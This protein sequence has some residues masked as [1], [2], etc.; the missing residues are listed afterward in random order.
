LDNAY[1]D[2]LI[3][4]KQ[5]VTSRLQHQ[6]IMELCLSF[7]CDVEWESMPSQVRGYL[8]QRVVGKPC[9]ISQDIE[10]W[11]FHRLEK[12]RKCD[13]ENF[14]ARRNYAACLITEQLDLF[15]R[16]LQHPTNSESPKRKSILDP[17]STIP[18]HTDKNSRQK[19]KELC[20]FICDKLRSCA[21]MLAVALVAD[22]EFQ[23]EL[24]YALQRTS[25]LTQYP[26]RILATRIWIFANTMQDLFLPHLLVCTKML[27]IQS[28]T[29]YF[30]FMADLIYRNY[31]KPFAEPKS[32]SDT[33]LFISKVS[34]K[35]LL[36]SFTKIWMEA[37][38]CRN[39]PAVTHQNRHLMIAYR[40]ATITPRTCDSFIERSTNMVMP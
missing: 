26:I 4:S 22:V 14:I 36:H 18:Q 6:Q 9:H 10:K 5:K 7:D 20:S 17:T 39:T 27:K 29:Y 37:S 31:G 11:L 19:F 33:R 16:L 21:K 23:R 15:Q 32:V 1:S 25:R 3:D 12:S 8:L 30:S 2:N 13:L 24:D 40:H 38:G 28:L 34:L 35:T